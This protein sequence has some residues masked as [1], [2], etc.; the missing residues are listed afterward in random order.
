MDVLKN[1]EAKTSEVRLGRAENERYDNLLPSCSSSSYK[2]HDFNLVS[3]MEL[4]G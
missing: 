1:K 4:K 3:I 2:I